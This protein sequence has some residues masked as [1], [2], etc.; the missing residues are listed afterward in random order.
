MHSTTQSGAS[1]TI[2]FNGWSI[3]PFPLDSFACLNFELPGTRLQM[4]CTVAMGTGNET[5]DFTFD[6]RTGPSLTRSSHP[7]ISYYK[8]G[9]FDSGPVPNAVHILTVSNGGGPSDTPFQVDYLTVN[10]SMVLPSGTA[11]SSGSLSASSTGSA[12]PTASNASTSHPS[13][14][15][16]SVSSNLVFLTALLPW[17]VL[18]LQ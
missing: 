15:C 2:T 14:T 11:A 18:K 16:L 3:S 7:D 13:G 9:W 4:F 1:A 6:G 5:V 17:Q 10:G 8:D 12:G